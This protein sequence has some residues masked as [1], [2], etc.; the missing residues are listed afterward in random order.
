MELLK[1]ARPTRGFGKLSF[2]TVSNL[3]YR[4]AKPIGIIISS[5]TMLR[6]LNIIPDKNYSTSRVLGIADW[7]FPKGNTYGT[8][9]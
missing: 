8:I 9:F 3:G 7:A 4:L 5:S 1:G 2:A 6:I